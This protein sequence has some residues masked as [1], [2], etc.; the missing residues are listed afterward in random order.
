MPSSSEIR[1]TLKRFEWL[2]RLLTFS[3][4]CLAVT[5]NEMNSNLL[6]YR[7]G[8]LVLSYYQPNQSERREKPEKR[9]REPVVRISL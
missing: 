5:T 7:F 3:L 9:T 8:K 4:D 2:I 1:A 6:S